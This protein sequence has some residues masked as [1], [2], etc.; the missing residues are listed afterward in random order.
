VIDSAVAPAAESALVAERSFEEAVLDHTGRLFGIAR[1]I[2]GDDQHAE[3]VVQEVMI[4]A[5]RSWA[6]TIDHASPG[7]WLTRICVNRCLS[8]RSRSR[9]L[10]LR[11]AE[12]DE[13]TASVPGPADPA[14]AERFGVLSRHQRAVVVLHYYQGYSLDECAQAMGCRPGTARSHLHRALRSLREVLSDA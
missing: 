7:P 6:R 11:T 4:R 3:D 12:L 14:L 1:A 2:V 9:M 5:W 8:H 10:R 13:A